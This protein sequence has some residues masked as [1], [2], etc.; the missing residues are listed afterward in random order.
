MNNPK[1]IDHFIKEMQRRNFS[2]MTIKNYA[3]NLGVFFKY[4]ENKEH[5]L[6]INQ[7][8]I[9]TY[10]GQFDEPNTQRSH[11]GAIKLHTY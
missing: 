7:D 11:H 6:H 2:Q 3:S 8:D 10:L 4:F 1:H 5:P 9:R